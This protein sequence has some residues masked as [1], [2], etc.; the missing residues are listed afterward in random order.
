MT[1]TQIA[2][3]DQFDALIGLAAPVLDLVL[4]LGD[5]VSR[6]VEPGPSDYYPVRPG[7][8]VA[9]PGEPG[10]DPEDTAL[11]AGGERRADTGAPGR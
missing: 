5:R 9:L 7:G 1:P 4:A 6:I 8:K 3:R 2:R 11:P 10:Y